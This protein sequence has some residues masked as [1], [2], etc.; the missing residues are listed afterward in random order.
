M[1]RLPAH[2]VEKQKTHDVGAQLHSAGN[3]EVNVDVPA[4]IANVEAQTVVYDIDDHPEVKWSQICHVVTVIH[5]L[6]I[7]SRVANYHN[8]QTN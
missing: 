1:Q 5:V 8:H 2:L 6:S 3:C 7:M 4:K